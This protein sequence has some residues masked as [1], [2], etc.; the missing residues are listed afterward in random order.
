LPGKLISIN[1]GLPRDVTW[2]GKIVRTGI[3][4][5]PVQGR[6][7]ARRLNLDGDGQGDLGGHGGLNRPVMVYQMDS[8]R[9][10]ER[11]LGR[12]GFSYG[13]FGENFTV[14]GLA[15][16][17]VCI[18]DRFRIGSALFE[19]SQPRVTCYR[20]GM[21][22]NDSQMAMKLVARHRPGFYFRLLEGGEVGAGDEIVK[23]AD[24][25]E[26]MSVAEVDAMLYLGARNR[27]Q[28]DRVL[29]IPALSQGWQ[30]SFQALLAEETSGS[31]TTGNAGL[32]P[33]DGPPPAWPGFRQLRASRK[34]R[35]SANIISLELVAADD[36]PLVAGL[37]GQFIVLR[38]QPEGTGSSLLRNYSLSGPPATDHYRVSVKREEKG[39]A[40]AYLHDRIQVGDLVDVA[41]PRGGFTLRSGNG[42]V[43]LISAGVGATPV[44]AMLHA[45]AQEISPRH[46]WW[47]F[48]ARNH[49]EHPFAAESRSLMQALPRCKSYIAYSRPGVRDRAGVDFDATGHLD[50]SVL[51]K[52]GIPLDAN[53]YICGP[54]A[55]MQ[56]WSAGLA[57]RGIPSAQVHAELFGPGKAM[58]PGIADATARQPHPPEGIA[59]S[60]PRVS[61]ARSGLSVPWDAKYPSLLDFAEACDVPVRWSCRTGVCHNCESGL[62]SGDVAYQ[63]EPLEPPAAGNLLICCSRPDGDVVIDL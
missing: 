37:P 30:G 31:P 4:K 23:V 56:D 60:G 51:E 2:R 53:F 1:V 5:S 48:G 47:L 35:E 18:G 38:I 42:P 63:P 44:L 3:W 6:V 40:S 12:Q 14:E 28:L 19:I 62:I 61:F 55:F 13:Q 24:G 43:V 16:S 59:G 25:A 17:E 54:A 11:E 29:R 39:V 26:R 49:D 20:V 50:I 8:Y 9:F 46:V 32:V 52:L 21:R 36:K 7:M 33:Q 15:D 58:T 45:L 57:A 41:A 22:M 10:W 34:Q 27:E